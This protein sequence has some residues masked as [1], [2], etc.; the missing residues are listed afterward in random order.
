MPNIRI[1]Y[2]IVLG[3]ITRTLNRST[4]YILSKAHTSLSPVTHTHTDTHSYSYLSGLI[5]GHAN[6]SAVGPLISPSISTCCTTWTSAERKTPHLS[7]VQTRVP[8]CLPVPLPFLP[9]W[10]SSYCPI[11]S[12]LFSPSTP[13]PHSYEL[14]CSDPSPSISFNWIMMCNHF[15]SGE[16]IKWS[17]ASAPPQRPPSVCSY[18]IQRPSFQGV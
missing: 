6:S 11:L 15:L 18:L 16:S 12:S 17:R 13:S 1:A 8:P 4:N 5:S 10:Q 9:G 7:F 14:Y 3:V 2:L